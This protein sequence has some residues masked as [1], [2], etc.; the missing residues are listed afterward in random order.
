MKDSGK[1]PF[2]LADNERLFIVANGP[3]RTTKDDIQFPATKAGRRFSTF[4]YT[5]IMPNDEAVNR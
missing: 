4:H 1:W 3:V 5:R 2:P